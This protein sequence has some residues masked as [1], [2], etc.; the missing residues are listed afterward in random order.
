MRPAH[1]IPDRVL[2]ALSHFRAE[3]RIPPIA[4]EDG[5]NALMLLRGAGIF[6]QMLLSEHRTGRP[7]FGL[8]ERCRERMREARFFVRPEE[9]A[10]RQ[11]PS[12][13]NQIEPLDAELG[14]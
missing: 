9:A 10:D 8:P 4:R 3:N 6:L 1:P 11:P 14:V 13:R 5:R 7:A 12:A 2:F